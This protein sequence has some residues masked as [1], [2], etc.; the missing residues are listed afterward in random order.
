LKDYVS[1]EK[2]NSLQKDKDYFLSFP[3]IGIQLDGKDGLLYLRCKAAFTDHIEEYE[4]QYY[5]IN[6]LMNS[7][8]PLSEE[9]LS[10][11]SIWY[12]P[13][14]LLH[15]LDA[16][17]MEEKYANGKNKFSV[18]LKK[19]LLHGNYKEFTPEGKL[20][21]KGKYRDGKQDGEWILYNN[22]GKEIEKKFFI[23]GKLSS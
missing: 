15:D 5:E 3:K 4:K 1:K 21:V 6:A 16:S 8:I 12:A 13:E 18:G 7:F 2:W 22:E 9:V 11:T 23:G 10:Q 17:K 20:R 14:I 19:G